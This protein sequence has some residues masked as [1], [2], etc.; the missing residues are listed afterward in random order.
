MKRVLSA[1][2]IIVCLLVMMTGADFRTRAT[3]SSPNLKIK[4]NCFGYTVIE[5]GKGVDCNGDTIRLIKKDGFYQLAA[6]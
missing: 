4:K 2:A 6:L 1:V 5:A 3:L